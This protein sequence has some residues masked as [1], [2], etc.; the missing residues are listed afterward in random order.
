MPQNTFIV[1]LLCFSLLVVLF[2]S[3]LFSFRSSP[4]LVYHESTSR[5]EKLRMD[6]RRITATHFRMQHSVRREPCRQRLAQLPAN[7][8]PRVPLVE[9]AGVATG[10][11]AITICTCIINGGGAVFFPNAVFRIRPQPRPHLPPLF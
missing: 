5:A 2:S 11:G 4:D 9:L 1:F 3:P 8:R 7:L 10:A 6:A